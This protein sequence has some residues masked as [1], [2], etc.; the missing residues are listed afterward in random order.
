MIEALHFF[1]IMETLGICSATKNNFAEKK[2]Y[3]TACIGENKHFAT[4]K[5][6][7]SPFRL[8]SYNLLYQRKTLIFEVLT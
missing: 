1:N 4:N 8:G 6:V 3:I 5:G 7:L 2:S